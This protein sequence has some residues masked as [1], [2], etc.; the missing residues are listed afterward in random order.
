MSQAKASKNK[1][2]FNFGRNTLWS[3]DPYELRIVG[4]KALPPEERGPLDT[5]DG[6]EADLHD[7]RLLVP[8]TAEYV[9]NID[10]FGVDTPI[11]IAKIDGVP[12][13]IVGRSRVRAA[14]IVNKRRKSRGEPLVKIDCKIKRGDGKTLLAAMISENEARRDDDVP[15]K[16]AK[17]KRLMNRGISAE[18]AGIIF[19][20]G[21][22][23]IKGWLA[24][25]DNAITETKKAV[26]AGRLSQ[27]AAATLARVKDP[28]EQK[29]A[30]D[31]ML[32]TEG[33]SS[34]RA[35]RVAAKQVDRGKIVGVTDKKTQRRL[36]EAVQST[37]H[38][39]ASE[40]TSAWWQGVEDALQLIVGDDEK[41]DARLTGK[42]DEVYALMKTEDRAKRLRKVKREEKSLDAGGGK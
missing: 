3:I 12:T 19:N 22:Q 35:A 6:D 1:R 27:T 38:P 36:L 28:A 7:S 41:V 14:R 37:P 9:N 21:Q 40:K 30:L 18:D 4:G 5:D 16:I 15:T 10:A 25:D 24:F 11:L 42:L 23:T 8:L 34:T 13:V 31:E 17:L 32:S 39:N 2:S 26:S 29:K 33:R 20:V